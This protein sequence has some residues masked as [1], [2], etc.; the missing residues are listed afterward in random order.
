MRVVLLHQPKPGRESPPSSLAQALAVP[1]I[2]FGDLIRAHLSGRTELGLRIAQL[3]DSNLPMP[4]EI[5]TAIVREAILHTSPASFVLDGHPRNIT[6]ARALDDLLR[7][8]GIPLDA[9]LHYGI[10]EEEAERRVQDQT[11]RRSCRNDPHHRYVPS[12]DT[13]AAEGLCNVCGGELFQREEDNEDSVRRR[14][15]SYEAT[16]EP[17]LRHYA[18]QGL[19]VT[20]NDDRT[21][22]EVA[23]RAVAALRR[24]LG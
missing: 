23:R 22:D 2:G 10:S 11:A 7:E 1:L 13:L 3:M 8:H 21:S 4:D 6:Q 17:I 9:V 18:E 24:H 15:T 16:T 5:S 14:F 20:V 19:L 12:A